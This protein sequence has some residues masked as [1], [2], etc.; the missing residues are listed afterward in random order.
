MDC[1]TSL[2][3]PQGQNTKLSG[4]RAN[5]QN[6][7]PL[8]LQVAAESARSMYKH[9]AT[10]SSRTH[11]PA[12]QQK[13]KRNQQIKKNGFVQQL[14]Q[15]SSM[16]WSLRC[17]TSRLILSPA[18]NPSLGALASNNILDGPPGSRKKSACCTTIQTICM[19]CIATIRE[20]RCMR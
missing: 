13:D 12:T 11:G 6:L 5:V 15:K 2:G 18:Q 20:R 10:S 7:R 17:R 8:P 4:P 14:A 9:R 3:A 1:G 19:T 16:A